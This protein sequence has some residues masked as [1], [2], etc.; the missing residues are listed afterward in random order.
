[1]IRSID[2]I[3]QRRREVAAMKARAIRERREADARI[4]ATRLRL[5]GDAPPYR[6]GKLGRI[7][8][9]GAGCRNGGGWPGEALGTWDLHG[10]I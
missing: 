4:H 10:R 1:M 9:A 8:Q 6:A 2:E 5:G 3:L 7:I